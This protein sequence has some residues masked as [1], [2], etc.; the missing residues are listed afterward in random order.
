MIKRLIFLGLLLLSG[1]SILPVSA[2]ILTIA[3]EHFPPYNYLDD[4]SKVVGINAEL[5]QRSCEIAAIDCSIQSYPWLRAMSLT[6]ENDYGALFSTLRSADRERQ[7]QWVGPLVKSRAILYRLKS[8]PEIQVTRLEDAKNYVVGVARGD[9]YE[10]YLQQNGFSYGKN[11]FG[12]ATK[13]EAANLFVQGKIDLLIGSWQI[14]PM[15]LAPYNATVDDVEEAFQL[16][17]LGDN[18][19]ALNLKVPKQMVDQLQQALQKLHESGEYQQILEK[20]QYAPQ[21]VSAQK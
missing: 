17:E 6:L 18:Y 21:H 20:Y 1:T 10:A 8:R 19:L 3:T 2:Q 7:F 16:R 4:N 12:F 9:V 11:L 14:L 5:V 15:W 13:A